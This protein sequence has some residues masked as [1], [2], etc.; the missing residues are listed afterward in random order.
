MKPGQCQVPGNPGVG[1]VG[2]TEGYLLQLGSIRRLPLVPGG[3]LK[4]LRGQ[5][6]L[7][8]P[9]LME[10]GRGVLSLPPAVPPS[11]LQVTDQSPTP[12]SVLQP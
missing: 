6:A 5:P 3:L 1:P 7:P 10:D 9:Q 4:L 8:Q 11:L 12:L 2:A